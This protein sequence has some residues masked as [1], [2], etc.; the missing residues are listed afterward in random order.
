MTSIESPC[1]DICQLNP[2]S[3]VCLGCFR[4]MD[5]ISVWVEMSDDDKREVL[6]LAKERQLLMLPEDD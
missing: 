6:L 4:T 1:V 3:G 5:E 2:A